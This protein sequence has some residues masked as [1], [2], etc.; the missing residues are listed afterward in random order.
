MRAIAILGLLTAV[1]VIDAGAAQAAHWCAGQ[2]CTF[3]SFVQC[4]RAMRGESGC[5]RQV[6]VR[7]APRAS[8]APAAPVPSI[9]SSRPAWASPYECYYDEGYGRYRACNAGGSM[10]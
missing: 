3:R 1:L 5:Y 6:V 10:Q 8:V 9:A 2:N 7:A 4:Q